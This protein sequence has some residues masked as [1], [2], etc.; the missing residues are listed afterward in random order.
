MWLMLQAEQPDDYVVASGETHSVREFVAAVFS[1]LGLDYEHYVK[2][3]PSFFRPAEKV[4]L[5]GNP[6][7]AVER[8]GWRRTKDFQ[9]IVAEMVASEMGMYERH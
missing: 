3:D 1:G 8:L 4:K 9:G 2:V 5:C 7:K 6:A